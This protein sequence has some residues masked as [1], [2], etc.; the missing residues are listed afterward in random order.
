MTYKIEITINNDEIIDIIEFD[1][2]KEFIHF[3]NDTD[4]LKEYR[5]KY[6]GCVL[7]SYEVYPDYDHTQNELRQYF[8]IFPDNPN[9]YQHSLPIADTQNSTTNDKEENSAGYI[10]GSTILGILLFP[11]FIIFGAIK[12]SK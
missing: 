8:R 10:I 12:S 4:R 1:T 5:I 9:N 11:I 2:F 6:R 7:R 3:F